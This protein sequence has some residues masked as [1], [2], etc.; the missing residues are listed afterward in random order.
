MVGHH[1]GVAAA[2]VGLVLHGSGYGM[3]DYLLFVN[4]DY[5]AEGNLAKRCERSIISIRS[6]D[7]LSWLERY[8]DTS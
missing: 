6:G 3:V 1:S 5:S 4:R 2:F 7:W 8:V